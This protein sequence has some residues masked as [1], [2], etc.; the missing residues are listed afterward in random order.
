MKKG[1]VLRVSVKIV[2]VLPLTSTCSSRLLVL[3]ILL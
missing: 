2:I 1:D 3:P